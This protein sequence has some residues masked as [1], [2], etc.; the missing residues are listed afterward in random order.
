V[1]LGQNPDV[2]IGTSR[3]QPPLPPRGLHKNMI[4][5]PVTNLLIRFSAVAIL[6]QVAVQGF[7][8]GAFDVP[9]RLRVPVPVLYEDAGTILD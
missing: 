1:K 9:A 2:K 4:I 7:F 8:D 3:R 6:R 5:N